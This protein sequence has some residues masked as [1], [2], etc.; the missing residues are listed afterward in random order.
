MVPDKLEA[1]YK[2]SEDK[3]T[4]LKEKKFIEKK[5]K[6]YS[7]IEHL[8]KLEFNLIPEGLAI[9][10]Y[11]E[12]AHGSLPEKGVNAVTWLFKCLSTFKKYKTNKLVSLIANVFHKDYFGEKSGIAHDDSEMG[13]VSQ[14]LSPFKYE[15][16]VA[17]FCLDIRYPNGT[18][19]SKI[20]AA[21]SKLAKKYSAQSVGLGDTKIHYVD[22][23]GELVTKLMSIY[24]THTNDYTSQ[25]MS[26]GGGTFAKVLNNCVAFGPQLPDK[27][28][29][30]HQ[31]NEFTSIEDFLLSIAIYTNAV[32]ELCK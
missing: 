2:L 14:N 26:I 17:E 4:A 8:E 10:L 1:V 19:S 21:M 13:K 12:S 31:A 30:I 16:G 11:G 23:K 3:Q 5:F 29:L 20:D 9:T 15:N 18:D 27:D 32:Y 25:P 6:D 7:K 24:Q 22:P 28:A